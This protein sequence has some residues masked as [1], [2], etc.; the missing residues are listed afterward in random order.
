M[1]SLNSK[2]AR[3]CIVNKK[4]HVLQT[5]Q[6]VKF[7]FNTVKLAQHI[8][9]EI[10][11]VSSLC[12]TKE[13]KDQVLPNAVHHQNRRKRRKSKKKCNINLEEIA[14]SLEIQVVRLLSTKW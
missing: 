5:D 8:I 13:Y 7:S 1:K 10:G 6:I 12:L 4:C 2:L 14:S 9:S 3:K 11:T